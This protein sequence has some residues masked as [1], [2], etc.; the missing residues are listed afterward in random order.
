MAPFSVGLEQM[1]K[2]LLA[3]SPMPAEAR[4]EPQMP[5]QA[6]NSAQ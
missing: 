2:P 6:P 5:G 1:R 4:A 3:A